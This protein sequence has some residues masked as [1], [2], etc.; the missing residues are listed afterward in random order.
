MAG[1]CPTRAG[2]S[3]RFGPRTGNVRW[4]FKTGAI[5]S[6]APAVGADGTIYIGSN[7]RNVYAI[8]PQGREK[9]RAA[10]AGNINDSGFVIGKDGTLYVGSGDGNL[11]AFSPDGQKKWATPVQGDVSFTPVAGGDGTLYIAGQNP[12]VSTPFFAIAVDGSTK[13]QTAAVFGSSAAAIGADG[14]V[15]VGGI[16]AKLYALRPGDGS[17]LWSAPT[18][19]P[20]VSPS[21]GGDGTIYVPDAKNL[22][23]FDPAGARRW[24]TAIAARASGVAIG[25]DDTIYVATQSKA[26]HAVRPTGDIKWTFS[27]S[28]SWT[29]APTIGGDGVVYV[30]GDDGT[31][32][33][34]SPD[35]TLLFTVATGGYINSQPA[36]GGDG[37]LYFVSADSLLYAIGL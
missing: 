36:I 5:A 30:G 24:S 28:A 22:Y 37:T 27:A 3:G 7:D 21:V 13:W 6:M 9:W 4:R 19:T 15:Y 8:D 1:F 25:P 11:N 2:R 16:D 29:R 20:P 26:L 18:V 17:V 35:G 31:L 32:Y 14:T 12:S 34:V 33:A 10:V 23:A